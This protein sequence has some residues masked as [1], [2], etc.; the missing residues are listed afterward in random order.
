MSAKI[1][2]G[3]PIAEEIRKEIIAETE[4]LK[5]KGLTPKLAVI[6]VGGDPASK[7]YAKS[8]IKV[9][10]KVGVKVELTEMPEDTPEEEVIKFIEKLNNDKDTHGILVELPLPKH[11]AKE[12]VMN[13][14]LPVKDVD[15]VTAV[16]RGYI[17]GGQEHLA[18]IP[19]TPLSCIELMVRS[20]IDLTGKRVALIGR[21]DTVGR[22]LASLLITR[23]ATIT[24]CHTRTKDMPS[25]TRQAEII[26]A[27]AGRKGLVTKD[28]VSPG[29]V[30]IDAGINEVTKEDGTTTIVGDVEFDEVKEVASAI[31]P[32][33]GGVGSLT[34]S[35]IMQNVL[36][37]MKLQGLY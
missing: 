3:M 5:E 9:G 8:K 28:M 11:I 36:K 25:I 6:L 4:K 27:A 22:P 29:T 35:I 23:H 1:I 15:G 2:K 7:W 16:N 34:T 13:A 37:A 21:G 18:L 17:F 14:I 26:V 31:T 19:A 32:V 30:V 33:P 12:K 20:G 10:D 24:V